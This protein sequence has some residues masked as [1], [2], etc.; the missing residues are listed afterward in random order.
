[1]AQGSRKVLGVNDVTFVYDQGI[2]VRSVQLSIGRQDVAAPWPAF[3]VT[4]RRDSA[5]AADTGHR[6]LDVREAGGYWF[7]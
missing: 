3:W 2:V 1:M 4:T 7:G 6:T 5:V